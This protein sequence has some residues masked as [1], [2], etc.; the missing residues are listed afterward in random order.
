MLV[1]QHPDRIPAECRGGVLAIGNFDGVHLGHQAVIGRAR[2][3]ARAAGVPLGVLTFEPHPRT[4][5]GKAGA[6]FRLTP[7]PIKRRHLEALQVDMLVELAF[8][9]KLA[10][11]PP[12]AFVDDLLVANFQP[13]H[14]VIGFDFCFGRDRQGNAALLTAMGAE[15]GFGVAIVEPVLDTESETYS[16]NL[17]RDYLVAGQPAR[18]AAL[19][20]HLWEIEGEVLRG[21]E[22][23]RT[24]GFPTANIALTDYLVPQLG[25]YAV[26]AGEDRGID[27][28]W[29]DAVAYIGRR[30]T[31][32]GE[33]LLLE[34]HLFDF[35]GDLYGAH[36]RV[37]LADFIRPDEAFDGLEALKTQIAADARQARQLLAARRIRA[38]DLGKRMDNAH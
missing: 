33:T 29:R 22:L 20:G 12:K 4:V 9:K 5:L 25:I 6:P 35:D 27:T 15:L 16:S 19:L 32:G 30:P 36:W 31:V 26:R 11:M 23:G 13:S 37:A 24:L 21:E 34:F 28:E 18:A 10:A 1:F 17:I 8:D 2:E 7:S 14:I 3:I 38:G